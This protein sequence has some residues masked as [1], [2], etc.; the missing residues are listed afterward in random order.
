MRYTLVVVI[1]DQTA[2][3]VM[4]V[5]YEHFIV[6]FG[7][8]AKLLS[9]RDVNFTST[10]VDAEVQNHSLPHLVQWTGGTLPPDAV[11]QDWQAGTQ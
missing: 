2:K 9:D 8:P 3:T 1:K 10:L 6:V 5:F 7:A 11:P 4:K